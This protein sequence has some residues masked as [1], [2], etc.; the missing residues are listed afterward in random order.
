MGMWR[1]LLASFLSLGLLAC[2]DGSSSSLAETGPV[3]SGSVE[4]ADLR[5]VSEWERL[6]RSAMDSDRRRS[7]PMARSGDS[8]DH[9]NLAYSVDG[10]TAMFEASLN[11]EYLTQPLEYINAVIA[12]AS[13]S[14]QLTNSSFK[15]NF[16]G[17]ASYKHPSRSL[18]GDEYP[19]FESYFWRYV[20]KL[21]RVMHDQ[22]DFIQNEQHLRSYDNIK[23]FLETHIFD[24]WT[25]RGKRHIYRNRT[26]MAAH[27]AL[28]ALE[29]RAFSES[30]RRLELAE[31]IVR[32]ID[33][34]MPIHGSSLRA[35]F[36]PNPTVDG[37]VIWYS[38]WNQSY[39]R[40]QDVAHGNNVVAYLVEAAERGS[41]WK[42]EDLRSI[43]ETL[44]QSLWPEP[45]PKRSFPAFVDGSGEGNGWFSDGF[46]KLGRIDPRIQ[47]KLEDHPIGRGVQLYGNAALNLRKLTERH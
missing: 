14:S 2:G 13:K 29:L 39:G 11:E 46:I 33:T 45:G 32:N 38:S 30:P 1:G 31:Q 34:N 27:W 41:H 26:H 25:S 22:S 42:V 17:W 4:L 7:W 10:F 8:W 5:S 12:S 19:L 20:A 6:F 15:D 23:N 21:L 37:G 44:L 28:I 16:L 43:G 35:Q 18:H 47:Q 9:Y 40:P 24:K 3:D 36:R